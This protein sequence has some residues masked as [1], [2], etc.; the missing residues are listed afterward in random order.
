M[1]WATS[2]PTRPRPTTASSSSSRV[3]A[4]GASTWWSRRRRS[5]P[6][7]A[8]GSAIRMR[9]ICEGSVLGVPQPGHHR[10]ERPADLLDLVLAGDRKSTRLNSSHVKISYAVFCLKKKKIRRFGEDFHNRQFRGRHRQDVP[11]AVY[12]I[13]L[14]LPVEC[15]PGSSD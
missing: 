9:A 1:R 2:V 13:A 6:A 4:A 10:P 14:H 8:S 3:M 15:A 11:H 12:E 5:T 7:S